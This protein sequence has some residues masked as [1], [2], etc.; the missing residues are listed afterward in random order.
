MRRR[1]VVA[2][3]ARRLDEVR[4]A[5]AQRQRLGV[6]GGHESGQAARIVAAQRVGGAVLGRHQRQVQHVAARQLGAH[7]QA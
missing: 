5:D 1:H 7:A 4:A 2:G 3:Q 6:H